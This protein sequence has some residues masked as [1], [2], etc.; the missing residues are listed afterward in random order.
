[1]TVTATAIAAAAIAATV[2]VTV[3]R[4]EAAG[5]RDGQQQHGGWN[6]KVFFHFDASDQKILVCKWDFLI[7]TP[8]SFLPCGMKRGLIAV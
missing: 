3:T 5:K 4:K 6:N 8:M 2:T 7:A 1:M